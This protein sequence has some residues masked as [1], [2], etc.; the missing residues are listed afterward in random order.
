MQPSPGNSPARCTRWR[1]RRRRPGKPGAEIPRA[2]LAV[3]PTSLPSCPAPAG[4]PIIRGNKAGTQA[5]GVL[6]RP[7]SRTITTSDASKRRAGPLRL[8]LLD[9]GLA[10]HRH[11]PQRGDA[12]ALAPQHAEAEPVEGETLAALRDRTRLVDHKSGHGGRLFVR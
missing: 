5:A 9:L 6:D 8:F 10:R 12:I 1:S 2:I 7:H 11:D 3:M 4:H